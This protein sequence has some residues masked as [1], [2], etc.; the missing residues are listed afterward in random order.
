M[1]LEGALPESIF[2]DLVSAEEIE[3]VHKLEVQGK[4]TLPFH[5]S[6]MQ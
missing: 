3:A 4:H 1:S 2:F 5:T 6:L